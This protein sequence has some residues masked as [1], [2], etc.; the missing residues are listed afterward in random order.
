MNYDEHGYYKDEPEQ[1]AVYWWRDGESLR[2]GD[3]SVYTFTVENMSGMETWW[4]VKHL[5][6]GETDECFKD[7]FEAMEWVEQQL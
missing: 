1:P 7:L 6:N 3:W 4:G 2:C 5:K